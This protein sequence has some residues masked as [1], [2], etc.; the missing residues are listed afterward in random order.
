[1]DHLQIFGPLVFND[2]ISQKAIFDGINP[3]T[4]KFKEYCK[5]ILNGEYQHISQLVVQRILFLMISKS[6]VDSVTY[7]LL[8][9][10]N[11]V[12]NNLAEKIQTD[13][14]NKTFSV[15][16]FFESYQKLVNTTKILCEV[17]SYYDN[18]TLCALNDMKFS[19]ITLMRN[20]SIYN[21]IINRKYNYNT[22]SLY[23]YELI[24]KFLE[25]KTDDDIDMV[26]L[27]FKIYQ[28][29]NRFSSIRAITEKGKQLF[30]MELLNKFS[31]NAD[32]N[33]LMNTINSLIIKLSAE[34]DENKAIKINNRL[35]DLLQLTLSTNDR[36]MFYIL[37]RNMLIDRIQSY[38]SNPEIER[39]MLK[40]CIS[41]KENAE[42]YITMHSIVTDAI[43]SRKYTSRFRTIK[44]ANKTGKYNDFD[45]TKFDRKLCNFMIQ[46]ASL[47]EKGYEPEG[48]KP[49]VEIDRYMDVFKRF[50]NKLE[51]NIE[52]YY[53]HSL[54]TGVLSMKFN[55]NKTYNILMTLPQMYVLLLLNE[56]EQMS[57][58]DMSETLNMPLF[59]L[60]KVLNSLID[61]NIIQREK[62]AA[63]DISLKFSINWDCVLPDNDVSIVNAFRKHM[64][65]QSNKQEQP[66]NT[67]NLDVLNARIMM[68]LTMHGKVTFDQLQTEINNLNNSLVDSKLIE[69]E[70]ANIVDQ[71][72]AVNEDGYYVYKSKEIDFDSDSDLISVSDD[73]HDNSVELENNKQVNESSNN[74]EK[75]EN[76]TI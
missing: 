31:I 8:D 15:N 74:Q 36:N 48:Y 5:S 47:L 61:F 6:G 32:Y 51:N 4:S 69:S 1:M 27:Q 37:Y 24:G 3:Y 73:E 42:M 53:V 28:F 18:N 65:A 54:S 19:V 60:G 10:Y 11:E 9:I 40:T 39:E 68:I 64:F 56:K 71:G 20:M 67:I 17:L 62:G 35:R 7:E 23:F 34:N 21:N 63:N 2:P 58:K 52:L 66:V 72:Y 25:I 75:I 44:L 33:L 16:E 76:I 12:T 57:P 41:M 22:E 55:D 49:P 30:N 26:I 38:T 70:L 45:F 13:V 29:Y 43:V 59:K 46:R 14:N 50:Y